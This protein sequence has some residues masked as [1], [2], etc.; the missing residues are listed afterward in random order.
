MKDVISVGSAEASA[1][2]LN[3]YSGKI[4]EN[5]SHGGNFPPV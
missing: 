5:V 1:G 2:Y 3:K 4:Q